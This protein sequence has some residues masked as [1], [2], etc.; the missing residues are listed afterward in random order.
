MVYYVYVESWALGFSLFSLTETY[1]G[2]E[3]LTGMRTFLSSYQG[4]GEGFFSSLLPACGFLLLTLG[5]NFYVLYR[6][7]SK[8]IERLALIAMPALVLFA[9]IL[10]IR[11]VLLGTP[12]PVNHPDWNVETGFAFIWNPNLTQ[13]TSP[14]VWLAAAGQ[15]FFTLSLGSGLIQTYASYVPAQD[16]IALG[17]LATSAL[18]EGVEV[19]LGASI[20]IPIATAFFGLTTTQEIAARGAYDLGFV[21]MPIIFAHIPFGQFFGF[22]WFLL[23]FIAGITSSVAM[24]QP[25]IAFL[26]EEF[27]YPHKKAIGVL[28]VMT[29]IPLTGVVFLF[30]GG[31]LDEMDYWVG[32]FGL[33][34]FALLEVIV[35]AWIYGIDKGW[36]E[37]T[38][39]A[40]IKV[41]RVFRFFI[42]YV[43]PIYL[44]VIMIYWLV[45][46]AVPILLMDQ[47]D[48]EQIPVRWLSRGVMVLLFAIVCYMVYRVWR[49]R[50]GSSAAVDR[51]VT[52]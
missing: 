44:L 52:Q 37:I 8:G 21:S 16:D 43:T 36:E 33:V 14:G 17:G 5:I 11:V 40:Q 10:V 32:T 4:V 12:D 42:K 49:R 25:L 3:T 48:T 27:A 38:R 29:L 7:L 23:L 30:S 9:V 39:G 28:A 6:G 18:N 47:M 24:S 13:L 2:Q 1:F 41:P 19:I 31:F 34:V 50:S 20:A 22:I 45:L 46:E 51:E 15:I 26:K 35:F